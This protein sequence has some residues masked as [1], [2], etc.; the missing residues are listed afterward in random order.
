[1][2]TAELSA[3]HRDATSET[4]PWNIWVD[5]VIRLVGCQVVDT[6]PHRERLQLWFRSGEPA[7]MAA[8]ALKAFIDGDRR[9]DQDR[10]DRR[11]IHRALVDAVD[12]EVKR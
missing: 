9:D 2:T 1:M 11:V 5:A 12:I 6:H 8:D 4:T 7:W 10:R 3:S